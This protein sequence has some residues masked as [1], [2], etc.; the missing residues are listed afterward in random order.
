LVIFVGAAPDSRAGR[1][2]AF[3]S[4]SPRSPRPAPQ[5]IAARPSRCGG[6]ALFLM[7]MLEPSNDNA[8][9]LLTVVG[10]SHRQPVRRRREIAPYG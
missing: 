3:R 2:T 4:D 1:L 10:G 7:P 8:C 5:A 6:D 9:H